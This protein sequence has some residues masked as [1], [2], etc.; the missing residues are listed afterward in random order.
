MQ[1]FD[2]MFNPFYMPASSKKF[3]DEEKNEEAR[4]NCIKTEIFIT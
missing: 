2:P 1:K 3:S 4:K